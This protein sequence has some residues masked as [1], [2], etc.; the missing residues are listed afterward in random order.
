MNAYN[1]VVEGII[2]VVAKSDGDAVSKALDMVNSLAGVLSDDFIPVSAEL[3]RSERDLG[4]G[5]TGDCL[6]YGS[7]DGKLIKEYFKTGG[8]GNGE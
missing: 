1:V 2:V 7:S 4:C 6:P 3:V 5:W 8:E